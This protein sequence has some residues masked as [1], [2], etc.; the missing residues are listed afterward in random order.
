MQP[1]VVEKKKTERPE[2]STN[3]AS[4]ENDENK[5]KEDTSNAPRRRTRRDT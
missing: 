5:E 3:Q 2:A 1:K 4:G